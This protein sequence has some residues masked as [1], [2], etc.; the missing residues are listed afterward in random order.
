MLP[1]AFV[2]HMTYVVRNGNCDTEGNYLDQD[3]DRRIT[4]FETRR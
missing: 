4:A 1:V 2:C 3:L